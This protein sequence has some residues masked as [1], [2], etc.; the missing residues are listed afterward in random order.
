MVIDGPKIPRRY[1]GNIEN[2]EVVRCMHRVCSSVTEVAMMW[3]EVLCTVV[4]SSNVHL[5]CVRAY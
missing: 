1:R 4:N 3:R 2:D 5:Y